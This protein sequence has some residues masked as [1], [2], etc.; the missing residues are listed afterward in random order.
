MLAVAKGSVYCGCGGEKES[1]HQHPT[2]GHFGI[3]KTLARITE[4]FVWPGM[5]KSVQ[6]VVSKSQTAGIFFN[7]QFQV[8]V[9]DVCQRTN[10][11]LATVAPELHPVPVVSPWYHLGIDLIG[12]ITP[13]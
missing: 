13:R 7:V 2:S 8:E 10:R 1:C 5:T 3:R 9:C 6:E 12:P 11:K 4:R